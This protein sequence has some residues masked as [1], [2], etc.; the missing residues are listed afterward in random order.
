MQPNNVLKRIFETRLYKSDSN[1]EECRK[2]VFRSP[3]FDILEVAL[4]FGLYNVVN[5]MVLNMAPVVSKGAWSKSIWEHA[6]ALEDAYWKASNTILRENDLLTMTVGNTRYLAW[7]RM[8]DSDY[9]AV[10][11]C[12]TMSR[13]VCHTSLLKKDDFRLKGLTMSHKTCI[14]CDL[15]CIEDIIHIISQCPY[16]HKERTEMYNEIYQKCP[17]AKDV[18]ERNSE[19]TIFYLLGRDIPSFD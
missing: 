4:I 3:I 19:N 12:E 10:K 9:S 14:M 18:F 2:N 6:W 16:Y 7:W 13:I 11:M 5:E 8:S 15:Y 1:T 17:K